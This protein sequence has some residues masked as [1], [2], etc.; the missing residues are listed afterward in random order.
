[1]IGTKKKKKERRIVAKIV[2]DITEHEWEYLNK[3]VKNGD[4]LGHYER[5]IVNGIP[6]PKGHFIAI[7]DPDYPI[8]EKAEKEIKETVFVGFDGCDEDSR[9]CFDIKEIIKDEGV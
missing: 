2:I 5:L 7:C 1:M 4:V 9:Y 6:L 3:L 8:T